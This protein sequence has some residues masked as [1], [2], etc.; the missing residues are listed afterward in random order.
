MGNQVIL[1]PA[2]IKILF[3]YLNSYFQEFLGNVRIGKNNHFEEKLITIFHK[4]N[5][6][7]IIIKKKQ[8]FTTIY[9]G[10]S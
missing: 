5:L 3:R 7:I 1:E 6:S 10:C 8:L 2:I 9:K 4:I